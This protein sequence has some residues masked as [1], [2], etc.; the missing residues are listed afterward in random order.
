MSDGRRRV[1]ATR[2]SLLRARAQLAQVRKGAHIIRR[3]REALVAQLFSLARPAVDAREVIQA[4]VNDAYAALGSALAVNGLDGLRALAQ[5]VQPVSVEL[6][7]AHIWGVSV[8]DITRAGTMRRTLDARGTAPGSTGPAAA[9]AATRF[10]K[11]ADL[12]LDAASREMRVA[13]LATAV[14]QTSQQLHV[15]EQ[16]LE[17]ALRHEVVTI[18][19]TLEEREREEHIALKHLQRRHA[20]GSRCSGESS[21]ER[22]R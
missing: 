9:E 16:R 17:T 15:L 8:A 7:P 3:K 6:H 11:L 21:I 20:E 2:S 19:R 13:R 5:P 18:R 22:E 1:A 10:E 12:L 14:A 4:S